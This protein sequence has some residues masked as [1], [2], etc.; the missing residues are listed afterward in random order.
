MAGIKSSGNPE[1]EDDTKGLLRYLR[2]PRSMDDLR[3]W[4]RVER[5][6]KRIPSSREW[7]INALTWLDIKGR[8]FKV[9]GKWLAGALR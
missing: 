3:K 2:K 6:E 7:L 8:A 1:W 4:R 9:N 5:L